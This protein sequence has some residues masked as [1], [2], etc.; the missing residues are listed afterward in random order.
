M[1]EWFGALEIF[2]KINAQWRGVE[3]H[4]PRGGKRANNN[5]E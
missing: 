3:V 5:V 2:C 1:A 4:Q